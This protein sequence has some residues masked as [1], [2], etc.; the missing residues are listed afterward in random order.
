M[1][2]FLTAKLYEEFHLANEGNAARRVS[3]YLTAFYI[4]LAFCILAPVIKWMNRNYLDID[5]NG[6]IIFAAFLVLA[7][8]VYNYIYRKFF[9]TNR[10][11]EVVKKY[12]QI[13]IPRLFIY[14]G[15]IFSI[16]ILIAIYSTMDRWLNGAKTFYLL[17]GNI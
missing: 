8:F 2:N 14:A 11:E 15:I 10:I 4:L 17:F 5:I 12:E 7:I 16:P 6:W 9:E 1:I 3:G 13:L